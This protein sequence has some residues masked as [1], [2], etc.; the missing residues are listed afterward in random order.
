MNQFVDIHRDQSPPID[1]AFIITF[2][3]GFKNNYDIAS[4][5]ISFHLNSIFP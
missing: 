2:D 3:D 4:K 5:L 1:N